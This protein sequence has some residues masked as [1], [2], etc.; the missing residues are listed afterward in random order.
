MIIEVEK[1]SG[2]QREEQEKRIEFYVKNGAILLQG[3]NYYLPSLNGHEKVEMNL[4]I[5]DDIDLPCI[6]GKEISQ[7]IT[8]IYNQVYQKGDN[9]DLI[10]FFSC[11]KLF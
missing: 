8:R 9:D 2:N 3:I 6:E 11:R 5:C 10:T 7:L 4:M 1:P